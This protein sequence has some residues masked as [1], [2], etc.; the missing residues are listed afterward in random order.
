MREPS[1]PASRAREIDRAF[2]ADEVVACLPFLLEAGYSARSAADHATILR[3]L[4]R[5]RRAPIDSEV[6]ERA[7]V[8]Q[9]ELAR[10]AHHRL[11]LPDVLIAAIADRHGTGVL[12]YD[13]DFDLILEHTTLSY[14]SAWLVWLWTGPGHSRPRR[15]HQP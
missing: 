3:Y 5:L 11:K 7:L 4:G 15:P 6:E 2:I 8:A 13:E 10:S 9:A 1:L 14:D 12:H